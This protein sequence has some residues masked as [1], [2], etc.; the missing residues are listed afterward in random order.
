MFGVCDRVTNDVLQ[1]DLED[2]TS[3]LVDETGDTLDTATAGQ[4]TNS[5]FGDTC[6]DVGD[7]EGCRTKKLTLDVV[8]KNFAM[9]LCTTLAE[10]LAATSNSQ[11][12]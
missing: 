2:T 9:T 3:F 12:V 7:D 11:K 10:T 6:N 8:T 1:E 5:G 4:T